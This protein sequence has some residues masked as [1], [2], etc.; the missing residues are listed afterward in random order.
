MVSHWTYCSAGEHDDLHQGDII[1]RDDRVV[2]ILN[3]AHKYFCSERYIAFLVVTQTCDLVR[4]KGRPCKANYI[5]GLLRF[6][7]NQGDLG[8]RRGG[9]VSEFSGNEIGHGD[10]VFD[11]AVAA[12]T[13]SRFLECAV[14]GLD[15]AVVLAGFEAVEDAGEVGGDRSGQA[16]EGIEATAPGPAQPALEEG[17]GFVGRSGRCVDGSQGLLDAPSPRGLEVGALQPV[18]GLELRDRPGGGILEQTPA[19]PLEFGLA[20]DLG[21]PHLV[22]RLAAECDDM[23]AVKAD[24]GLREV[25][26][27]AGLKRTAHIHADMRDRLW[28]ATMHGQVLGEP[29]QAGLVPAGRGK[30][31][32]LRIQIIENREVLLAPPASRLID[33]DRAHLGM[34]L[35]GTGLA[36]M[37]LDDPPQPT[38]RY[39]NQAASREHRHGRCEHQRQGFEQ[40]REA[41][42]L[43]CPRHGNLRHLPAARARHSRHFGV[44]VG[45]VLEEVQ[46][47]PVARQSIMERLR[48]RSTGRADV[49]A[50]AKRH[51][52]VNPAGLPVEVDLLDLPRSNQAQRLGEEHLDH[53]LSRHQQKAAIVLQADGGC[54]PPSALRKRWRGYDDVKDIVVPSMPI[55]RRRFH[56]K[57]HRPTNN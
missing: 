11:A 24:G 52:K 25:L 4:R 16:L 47:S 18:H 23:K 38:R 48:R 21:A 55:R 22:E 20:L 53:D 29:L 46:M 19:R 28:L 51:V 39:T 49:P 54:L 27:G 32:A 36:D 7:W 10:E 42:P 1:C 34:R 41:T 3:D 17:P 15:A 2:E 12:S 44:Q 57:R 35:F 37:V 30:D 56:T 33:S 50:A 5:S 45:L 9:Q 6:V 13:G 26:G 14:H 40:E 43:A 8:K 31:Q